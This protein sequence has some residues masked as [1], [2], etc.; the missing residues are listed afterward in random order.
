MSCGAPIV[1]KGSPL[2]RPPR[3]CR[4]A[5]RLP[6]ERRSPFGVLLRVDELPVAGDVAV[7][8]ADDEHDQV[9]VADVRNLPRGRRLDVAQTARAELA[10]LAVDL[11][12]GRA[13][14]DEVEL[15]LD[16]VVVEKALEL[17][18]VHDRVD[19]ECRNAE[20][21]PHLAE[22]GAVAELVDRSEAVGHVL[23]SFVVS[24]IASSAARPDARAVHG[25]DREFWCVR[26][27]SAPGAMLPRRRRPP[28]SRRRTRGRS[29]SSYPSEPARGRAS[30]ARR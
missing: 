9:V 27:R 14:V 24:P 3:G 30:A 7:L 19:A 5:A 18:R 20:L 16:V 26:C 11:E 10:Y 29:L 4:A 15:V 25:R 1:L 28:R 2:V 23:A 6:P 8:A 22:P 17:R 21:L 13:R 12:P